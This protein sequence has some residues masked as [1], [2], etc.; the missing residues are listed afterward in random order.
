[1]ATC[2]FVTSCDDAITISDNIIIM[3]FGELS[4]LNMISALALAA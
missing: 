1:M 3:A 2:E 4:L